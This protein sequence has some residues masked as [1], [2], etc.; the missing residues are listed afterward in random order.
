MVKR[1]N[2]LVVQMLRTYVERM[3]WERWLSLLLYA[4]RTSV[5]ASTGTTPF[6]VMFGRQQDSFL[7]PYKEQTYVG[8]PEHYRD[9]LHRTLAELHEFVEANLVKAGE[10]Q[11]RGYDLR[12]DR[13]RYFEGDDVWPSNPVRQIGS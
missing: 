9:H 4:F 8:N 5:H 1:A 3:E 6:E 10:I 11:K 13:P 12:S 2:R 7:L